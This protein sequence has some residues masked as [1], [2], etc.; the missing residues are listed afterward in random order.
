M[1]SL[2]AAE[3]SCTAKFNIRLIPRRQT[4]G[5]QAGGGVNV[6]L[7]GHFL[8]LQSDYFYIFGDELGDGTHAARIQLDA[9]F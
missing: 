2:S 6:Y 4:A 8:K 7:N 1:G 3:Q 9:S 5:R